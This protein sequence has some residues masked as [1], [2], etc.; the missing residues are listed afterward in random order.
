M[1]SYLVFKIAHCCEFPKLSIC[2]K[3]NCEFD[4]VTFWYQVLWRHKSSL[5]FYEVFNEFVSVH[6]GFLF[7]KDTPRISSHGTKF[8]EK[9]G[10]LEKMENYNVIRI[11]GS[12]ENPSF[13]PCHISDIMFFIEVARKYNLL[14]HFFH[15]K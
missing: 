11:F 15:K 6:K 12:K 5:Y 7:G 4:P 14:L 9:N 2:K 3:V 13:L 1:S 10:T 8:L